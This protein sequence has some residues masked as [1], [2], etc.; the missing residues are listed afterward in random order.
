MAVFA[1]FGTVELLFHIPGML[2]KPGGSM[3]RFL[4]SPETGAPAPI[5]G[6]KTFVNRPNQKFT[7][8]AHACC[9]YRVTINSHGFRG[10]ELPMKKPAGVFRVAIIGDSFVYGAG[11][12]DDETAGAVLEKLLNG[13]HATR[14]YEVMNAGLTGS[15]I[16]DELI[17]YKEY[18][19]KFTPDAVVLGYSWN[20]VLDIIKRETDESLAP[21]AGE[22]Q[23]R[24]WALIMKSAAARF[25]MY[26][27]AK[28]QKQKMVALFKTKRG[29]FDWAMK[30]DTVPRGRNS[31]LEAAIAEYKK[32]LLSFRDATER[33][34]ASFVFL[35][36]PT[37]IE[38]SRM[39]RDVGAE[40]F[41]FARKNRIPALMLKPLWLSRHKDIFSFFNPT[42][43]ATVEANIFIAKELKKLMKRSE[44]LY[45]EKPGE[46]RRVRM[47]AE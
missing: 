18:V 38:E 15:T 6:G 33:R 32:D 30:V 25:L 28:R 7:D 45:T 14:G 10:A 36:Y 19:R 3:P 40:L 11:V 24:L 22:Y 27:Y 2:N 37:M 29:D 31:V 17:L 5:T 46:Y 34:G 43:H 1:F 39:K 41:V 16:T 26:Q 23:S 42:E 4:N 47:R 44:T 8:T 13:N 20:D 9:S 21:S 12:D 35:V